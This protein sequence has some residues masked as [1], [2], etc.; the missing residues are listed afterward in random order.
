VADLLDRVLGPTLRTE[1][2]AA[3]L[4]ARL[5]DRLE[6]QLEAG[7]H[8][9][10]ARG[11]DAEAPELARRLGD[12]PLAHRQRREPARLEIVSQLAQEPVASGVDGAWFDAIDS[13]RPCSSVAPHAVPRDQQER[14]IA[15]E[16][17][18]VPEPTIRA[19]GRPL[20]QLGLDSQYPRPSLIEV[21]PRR[22]GIHRRPPGV[23]A[24][25]PLTR[26]IP[27]PCD[28]L[29]RP[30]TTT[31]PPSR[32]GAISRQR[33]CP[34]PPQRATARAT[35]GRFPRSPRLDRRGRRPALPLQHRREY[36]A[37][38][39]RGLPTDC[40]RSAPESPPTRSRTA[41]AAIRPTSTRLEPA[42]RLRGFNHWFTSVAPSCLARRAL[43]RP[44]V[45]TRLA[46]VGAAPTLTRASG[47]GLPPASSDCCDSPTAEPFHLRSIT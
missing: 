45:P 18:Q 26:W 40:I 5:E 19:V 29:S 32:P 28:R 44:V 2:V 6:D 46:F 17:E 31:D 10:V 7:L 37:D 42:S 47:I 1:A 11:R 34:P 20:V 8:D 43:G 36:A 25:V 22:A 4:E 9:A 16:T 30:R 14:G 21:R 35:P 3:R 41:C 13:G 15:D 27:S 33:A 24:T 23:P 12:H 38:L 39:P